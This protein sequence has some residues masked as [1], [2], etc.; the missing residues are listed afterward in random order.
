MSGV[1]V[2]ADPSTA[3]RYAIAFRSGQRLVITVTENN[4]NDWA[5]A[6]TV[7]ELSSGG[8]FG[9]RA[10]RFSPSGALAVM[11]KAIYPDD[12]FDAWSAVSLDH[13]RTFHTVRVSHARSHVAPA[14]RNNFMLGDDLSS[15]DVDGRYVYVVW[16]DNRAGFEGTWFGRVPLSAY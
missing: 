14:D 2:A 16:G 7:A 3:G 15:I 4:G 12:S 6:V 8:R 10:M 11:W 9:H 13:G 1:L 5:A